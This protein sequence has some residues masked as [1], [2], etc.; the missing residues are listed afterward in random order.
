MYYE[1]NYGKGS[2]EGFSEY[3]R[4]CKYC[5]KKYYTACRYSHVCDECKKKGGVRNGS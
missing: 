4:F 5:G 3:M 1:L 2:R